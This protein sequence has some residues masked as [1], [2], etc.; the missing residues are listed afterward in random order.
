MTND[1][2]KYSP[3]EVAQWIEDYAAAAREHLK[4]AEA[5]TKNKQSPEYRRMAIDVAIQAGLGE[6]FGAKFRAGM[7]YRIYR[8]D[9]GPRGA[10]ELCS[11]ISEG[12]R[13]L[14]LARPKGKGCVHV[15]HHGRR[16]STTKRALA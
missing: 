4:S 8:E 11:S 13:C 1:D 15:R 7:L 5:Q 10:L 6:F 16:A 2:G 3:L 14:G 9:R 12:A